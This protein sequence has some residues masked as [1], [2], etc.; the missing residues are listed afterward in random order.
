ML[1]KELTVKG[2]KIRSRNVLKNGIVAGAE[3]VVP[4]IT[5]T[6]GPGS[7]FDGCI[8]IPPNVTFEV[9]DKPKKKSGINVVKVLYQGH[10]GYVYWC[11]L[12]VSCDHI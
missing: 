10:E 5:M 1:K 8:S 12:R 6:Q 7:V 3:G 9:A 4:Y 11:E 2:A